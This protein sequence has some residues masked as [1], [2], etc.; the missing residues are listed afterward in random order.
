MLTA[1]FFCVCCIF[2]ALHYLRHDVIVQRSK[3]T[4]RC[5]CEPI[6]KQLFDKDEEAI[7]AL[8]MLSEYDSFCGR[9]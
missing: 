1:I 7:G 3:T 6:E 2:Y 5:T 8:W 9:E 4:C